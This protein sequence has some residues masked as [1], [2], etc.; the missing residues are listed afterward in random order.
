[1]KQYEYECICGYVW[2]DDVQ[3]YWDNCHTCPMC[4]ERTKITVEP[5]ESLPPDKLD[6]GN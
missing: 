6:R 4:N 5:Y 2:I 3:T 1:M